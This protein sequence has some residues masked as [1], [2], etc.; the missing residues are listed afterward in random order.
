M[1]DRSPE[2]GKPRRFNSA[3][4]HHIFIIY[5]LLF[6]CCCAQTRL[7]AVPFPR[8]HPRLVM[9][10]ANFNSSMCVIQNCL[11]AGVH[12]T[13]PRG[14]SVTYVSGTKCYLCVD[15]LIICLPLRAVLQ[16]LP[17]VVAA[18]N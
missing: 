9:K 10:V 2:K 12:T 4:G 18:H 13:T 3:P 17:L 5:L 1:G 7:V 14:E 6:A 8:L 15:P 16:A 11:T